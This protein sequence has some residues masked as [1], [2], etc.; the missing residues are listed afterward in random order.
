MLAFWV[1]GGSVDA[2]GTLQ[3]LSEGG[4]GT[5]SA[6]S[7]RLNDRKSSLGTANRS[8]KLVRDG[9]ALEKAFEKVVEK[10][11]EKAVEKKEV[12]KNWMQ[13]NVLGTT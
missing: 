6:P 4:L 8:K 2:P 3:R 12:E 7:R 10:V 9:D 5:L 1:S 11:V 13:Q